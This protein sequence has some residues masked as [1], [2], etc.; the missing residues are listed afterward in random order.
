MPSNFSALL[1]ICWAELIFWAFN[2]NSKAT[3]GMDTGNLS[4]SAFIP[5]TANTPASLDYYSQNS[6]LAT[7]QVC[8]SFFGFQLCDENS[9]MRRVIV[10]SKALTCYVLITTN[11]RC[12]KE[13]PHSMRL[14][15]SKTKI[16]HPSATNIRS[17]SKFNL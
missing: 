16:F 11:Y 1:I 5:A 8:Y 4:S 12:A 15:G 10:S 7:Q 17:A 9:N 6:S 14:G 3:T 13:L 2:R